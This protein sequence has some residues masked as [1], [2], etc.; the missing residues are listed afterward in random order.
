MPHP[1]ALPRPVAATRMETRAALLAHLRAEALEIMRE[2]P[3]AYPAD[4]A[5]YA[6]VIAQAGRVIGPDGAIWYEFLWAEPRHHMT[7]WATV[8]TRGV[9][10]GYDPYE[11]GGLAEPFEPP[12]V[13]RYPF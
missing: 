10:Q 2:D 6:P 8:T 4:Y 12:L 13:E 1:L 5:D 9:A 3:T 11:Q 7:M